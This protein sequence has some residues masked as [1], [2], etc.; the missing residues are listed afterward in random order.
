VS[1]DKDQVANFI[2]AVGTFSVLFALGYGVR[3][4]RAPES[5]VLS[6]LSGVVFIVVGLFVLARYAED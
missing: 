6:C 2:L 5:I 3:E 4:N 1:L